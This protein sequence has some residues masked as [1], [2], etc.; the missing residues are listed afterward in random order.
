[1]LH[2]LLLPRIIIRRAIDHVVKKEHGSSAVDSAADSLTAS[3]LN[4][5][6]QSYSE[7]WTAVTSQLTDYKQR[8]M[9]L[10]AK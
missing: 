1:M 6:L 2:L 9:Q 10:S 5:H 7:G 4:A 3:R 8:Q